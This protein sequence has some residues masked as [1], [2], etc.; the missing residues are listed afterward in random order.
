M[1][2]F[3]SAAE[4]S[5]D[6]IGAAF[7]RALRAAHPGVELHGLAGPAMREAGVAPVARVEELSVMGA[8]EVLARLPQVLG[9]RRRI[10]RALL[11]GPR[12]DLAVFIDSAD[13][14]LPLAARARARGMRTIGLGSP[15][16]W[17]WRPGRAPAVLR[18]YDR[19]ACFFAFEPAIYAGAAP[20]QVRWLGHPLADRP[21]ARRTADPDH[22]ALCPGSRPSELRRHLGP[23]VAAA[24][25]HGAPRR[26]LLLPAGLDPGPLPAGLRV[27]RTLDEIAD[28]RAV[29]TK[30]G[31]ITLELAAAGL[32]FVVAHRV[33]PL[34]W[35]LG[36][37]LVRGVRHLALPNILAGAEVAPE[38]L[39]RLD[40]AEL[41]H[42]L[43]AL[44]AD[45][46]A[47]PAGALGEPG[48]AARAVDWAL[49]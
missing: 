11:G 26:T 15:Q 31:T 34:T 29:L 38:R 12:W 22:L 17:A 2:A 14:H 47:L 13:L 48:F 18:A 41:A 27:A 43:R 44:P 5:G 33:H 8:A 1:R 10:A 7:A 32:P 6:R 40:P 23:F 9:V 28:A 21:T 49:S 37:L 35:A 36:R 30:S 25:A 46:P 24:A 45:G 4:P 42:L 39:Q 20:G 16:L 3:L 19:L